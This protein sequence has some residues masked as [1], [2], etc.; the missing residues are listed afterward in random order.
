MSPARYT[1]SSVF[2]AFKHVEVYVPRWLV[3]CRVRTLD[4]LSDTVLQPYQKRTIVNY[5]VYYG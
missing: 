3:Q 5:I 1:V 4:H 2:K